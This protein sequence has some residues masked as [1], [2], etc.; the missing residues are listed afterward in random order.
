MWSN[1]FPAEASRQLVQL[2]FAEPIADLLAELSGDADA[3]VCARITEV[4][5]SDE[6]H[7]N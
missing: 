3:G 5:K 2:W 1:D 6:T 4:M 7:L